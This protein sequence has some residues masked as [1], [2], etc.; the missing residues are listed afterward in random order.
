MFRQLTKTIRKE[1][2]EKIVVKSVAAVDSAWVDRLGTLA[3]K[4]RAEIDLTIEF[5]LGLNLF[6]VHVTNG[7][8]DGVILVDYDPNFAQRYGN[9]EP[10]QLLSPHFGPEEYWFAELLEMAQDEAQ[11]EPSEDPMGDGAEPK[12][13]P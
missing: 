11:S 7:E 3:G 9:Q 1:T 4:T 13:H 6:A 5:A 8:R 12:V 10:H 2:G